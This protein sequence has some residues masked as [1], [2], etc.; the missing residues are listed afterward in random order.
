MG[1]SSRSSRAS[2]HQFRN[3]A[4]YIERSR[5]HASRYVR[6]KARRMGIGVQ[7]DKCGHLLYHST[8]ILPYRYHYMLHLNC[9]VLQLGVH[10]SVECYDVMIGG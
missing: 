5:V 6:S 3:C 4:K 1:R 10:K 2:L 9:F 7:C 8:Y